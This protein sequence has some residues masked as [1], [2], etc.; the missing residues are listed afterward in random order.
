MLD[1]IFKFLNK[2]FSQ[3]APPPIFFPGMIGAMSVG[4]TR[5]ATGNVVVLC[6]D[7]FVLRGTARINRRRVVGGKRGVSNALTIKR[8]EDGFYLTA[9]RSLRR[10]PPWVGRDN[11]F[12]METPWVGVPRNACIPVKEIQYR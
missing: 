3:P 12:A 10:K 5:Y 7:G 6:E 8:K 9:P 1:R 11:I 2:L 4:Q